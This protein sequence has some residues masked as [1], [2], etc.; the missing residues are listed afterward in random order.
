MEMQGLAGICVGLG[1]PEEDDNGNR[2]GYNKGANC[3]GKFFNHKYINIFYFEMITI[4]ALC[5]K[6]EFSFSF[7]LL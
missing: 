4:L 7:F 3:S 6:L 2:I 5:F 1:T